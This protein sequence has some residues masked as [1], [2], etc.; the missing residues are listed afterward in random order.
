MIIEHQTPR[1]H[2]PHHSRGMLDSL[3]SSTG[4]SCC[5]SVPEED[6]QHTARSD[7]TRSTDSDDVIGSSDM[8]AINGQDVCPP[9]EVSGIESDTDSTKAEKEEERDV[10][11]PGAGRSNGLLY[12]RTSDGTLQDEIMG[13]RIHGQLQKSKSLNTD[14]EGEGEDGK[15][16]GHP[17]SQ[18]VPIP[19]ASRACLYS[20]AQTLVA[21]DNIAPYDGG[22]GRG[23]DSGI[24]PGD[25]E[26]FKFPSPTDEER[27]DASIAAIVSSC[28]PGDNTPIC[29]SPNI[30]T[31]KSGVESSTPTSEGVAKES[32]DQHGGYTFRSSPAHSRF[33]FSGASSDEM[34]ELDRHSNMTPPS[35]Q[36]AQSWTSSE[37][38]FRL[39]TPSIPWAPP[40]SPLPHSLPTSPTHYSIHQTSR[41]RPHRRSYDITTS[42]NMTSCLRK[43]S[44]SC[45]PHSCRNSA[46]FP[47]LQGDSSDFK[48]SVHFV[49]L[50]GSEQFYSDGDYRTLTSIGAV[51]PRSKS[52]P[53][54]PTMIRDREDKPG[55]C[56]VIRLKSDW[57]NQDPH[58]C[59]CYKIAQ[60]SNTRLSNSA[61]DL[62]KLMIPL[63]T[64]SASSPA[65]PPQTSLN[66]DSKHY[67]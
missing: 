48:K 63:L 67:S 58:S 65:V 6:E 53:P 59:K 61:P 14:G 8:A 29:T 16:K 11:L 4:S 26:V 25:V 2:R 47:E 1:H 56:G 22:I 18:Q 13:S 46:L 37:F 52:N 50:D 10:Y 43:T 45:H 64:V 9:V 41:Q 24:D 28:D 54:N 62:S 66:G 36:T 55:E 7:T 3:G 12:R 57:I 33:S 49:D 15:L 35:D 32:G 42:S 5:G 60:R 31:T 38:S 20:S 27:K 40:S 44:S 30:S 23:G 19:L 39:P 21:E 17:A 51:R 34:L